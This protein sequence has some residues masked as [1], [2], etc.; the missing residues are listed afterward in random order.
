[1]VRGVLVCIN[2]SSDFVQF[3]L[4][5]DSNSEN[6]LKVSA[7]EYPYESVREKQGKEI[8]VEN[9]YIWCLLFRSMGV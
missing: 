6:V 1:V 9:R 5:D 3:V 4:V 7:S 2:F 8:T